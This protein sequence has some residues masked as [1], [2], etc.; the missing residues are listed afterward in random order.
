M[1]TFFKMIVSTEKWEILHWIYRFS[2]LFMLRHFGPR[3]L[4]SHTKSSFL[5]RKTPFLKNEFA[6]KRSLFANK[7]TSYRAF[8][9]FRS[10][11][12]AYCGLVLGLRQFLLLP[13]LPKK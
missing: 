10:A 12:F 11:K 3:I 9:E 5:T 4:N 6:H 7:T 1:N 8:Y 13:Q 2:P